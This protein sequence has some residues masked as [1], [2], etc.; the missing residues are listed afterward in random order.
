MGTE[1]NTHNITFPCRLDSIT[2]VKST[3]MTSTWIFLYNLVGAEKMQIS[4]K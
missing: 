4:V 3:S 1:V 2:G